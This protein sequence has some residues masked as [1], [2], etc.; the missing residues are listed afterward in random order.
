MTGTTGT[1]KSWPK[2]DKSV[3]HEDG[4][5]ISKGEW[6]SILGTAN[7]VKKDLLS[8]PHR[9]GRTSCD[10]RTRTYFHKN[11]PKEWDSA[12]DKMENLEPLLGLCTLHWKAEHIIGSVLLRSHGSKSSDDH[13][14]DEESEGNE[15]P[16]SPASSSQKR[17]GSSSLR[18]TKKKR[19][20]LPEEMGLFF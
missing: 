15:C 14:Q 13:T 5:L 20:S 7:E 18:T 3:R 9:K 1:N 12:I 11:F 17:R 16:Q 2:M 10:S 4:T 8:L 19:K 6:A